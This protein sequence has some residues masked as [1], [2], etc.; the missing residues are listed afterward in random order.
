MLSAKEKGGAYVPHEDSSGIAFIKG[1][2]CYGGVLWG[3]EMMR[4]GPGVVERSLK[5]ALCANGKGDSST[6]TTTGGIS[7]NIYMMVMTPNGENSITCLVEADAR[8]KK[9]FVKR[10][11]VMLLIL[12]D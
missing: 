10:M 5:D 1:E 12:G 6:I 9:A 3:N 4:H 7:R 2:K 11:V 8:S